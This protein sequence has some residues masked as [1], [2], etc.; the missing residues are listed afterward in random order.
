MIGSC[1]Q[2]RAGRLRHT[3]RAY[4][5]CQRSLMGKE[6]FQKA[7]QFQQKLPMQRRMAWQAGTR[8]LRLSVIASDP[9]QG[10]KRP[11]W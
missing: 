3:K 4:R 8:T 6:L 9:R 10:N 5:T 11:E 1:C 2:S 7:I